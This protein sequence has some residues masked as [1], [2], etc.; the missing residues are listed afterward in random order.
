MSVSAVI[1]A[2]FV[3]AATASIA[4][5]Y[6]LGH[7]AG[8][9]SVERDWAKERALAASATANLQ[10]RYREREKEM[11]REREIVEQNYIALVD[12]SRAAADAAGTELDRLRR[13]LAARSERRAAESTACTASADDSAAERELLGACAAEYQ[14]L[15]READEITDRLRGLQEHQRVAQRDGG[16]D[17]VHQD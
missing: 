15:A 14:A 16:T 3:A 12:R 9:A 11:L 6:W 7:R 5:A 2:V 8:T 4:G 10:T 17:A 13:T 1:T